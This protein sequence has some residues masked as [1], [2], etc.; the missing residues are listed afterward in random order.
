MQKIR[1]HMIF[2]GQVQ[3]VGFRWN[4]CCIARQYGISGW[5][6]NNYDGTVEMEAEGTPGDLDRLVAELHRGRWIEITEIE[7][8]EVPVQGGYG[9][10]SD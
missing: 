8:R 1:R 3:G 5:V 7:S 4:A 2:H 6:R 10:E 9:F